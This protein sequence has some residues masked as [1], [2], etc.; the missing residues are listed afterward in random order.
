MTNQERAAIALHRMQGDMSL[1]RCNALAQALADDG[2]LMPEDMETQFGVE[3]LV[4]GE[5][6]QHIDMLSNEVWDS[7]KKFAE[8]TLDY[9][10]DTGHEA[11]LMKRQVSSPEVSQ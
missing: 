4:N 10:I 9:F 8:D 3:I 6:D 5:W 11:R 1:S 2:L 7:D